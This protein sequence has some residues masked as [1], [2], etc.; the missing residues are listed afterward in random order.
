MLGSHDADSW[1]LTT[2]AL[3]ERRAQRKLSHRST[4]R[5]PV[6]PEKR[7]E[8]ERKPAQAP[9]PADQLLSP[10]KVV[11]GV[12]L[13]KTKKASAPRYLNDTHTRENRAQN[14]P[15]APRPTPPKERGL[16]A[17]AAPRDVVAASFTSAALAFTRAEAAA[18]AEAL[19]EW[20]LAE[21]TAQWEAE[22]ARIA[23]QV[24]TDQEAVAAQGPSMTSQLHAVQE[25]RDEGPSEVAARPP[26]ETLATRTST[27]T[28]TAE[29]RSALCE[30]RGRPWTATAATIAAAVGL[31]AIV[32]GRI[33]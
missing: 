24:Q 17:S 1:L 19:D 13:R 27:R 32:A 3:R 8:E 2:E 5:R 6:R 21:E 25:A 12:A 20:E 15:T 14:T 11:F 16:R 30:A 29:A 23:I 33:R 18:V 7:V 26:S 10:E 28:P 4:P 22:V 9:Q 31:V